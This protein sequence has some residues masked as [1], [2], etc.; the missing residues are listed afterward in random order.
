[1][2]PVNAQVGAS[3][4]A[5]IIAAI[6]AKLT[7]IVELG[8]LA[9]YGAA[10]NYVYSML[11]D[12]QKKFSAFR[13][14]GLLFLATFIGNFFG[15]FIPADTKVRDE[16]LMGFGFCT[17]PLLALLEKRIEQLAIKYLDKRV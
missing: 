14:L 12:E 10:A 8:L 2:E 1:M 9:S 4:V 5:E 16:L 3:T 11:K 17:F 6:A 13:F 15:G 7:R